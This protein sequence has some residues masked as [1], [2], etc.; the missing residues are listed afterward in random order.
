MNGGRRESSYGCVQVGRLA[1]QSTDE[2]NP[3][4]HGG[5]P[6]RTDLIGN[7]WFQTFSLSPQMGSD[8]TGA[9]QNI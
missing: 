3:S 6:I 5:I 1:Q 9:V 8:Y 2:R 4:H 7:G